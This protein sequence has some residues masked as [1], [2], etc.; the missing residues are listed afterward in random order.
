M[1]RE[2]GESKKERKRTESEGVGGVERAGRRERE[3]GRGGERAVSLS[4]SVL[5]QNAKINQKH[6]LLVREL[7][8]LINQPSPVPSHHSM[9]NNSRM[10]ITEKLNMQSFQAHLA[11]TCTPQQIS[12]IIHVPHVVVIMVYTASPTPHSTIIDTIV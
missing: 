8:D 9:E 2:G 4:S 3:R 10:V 5:L 1:E 7:S 11:G 6:D 12:T